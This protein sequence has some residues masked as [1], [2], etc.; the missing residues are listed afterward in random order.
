MS[1]DALYFR[2]SSDRQTAEN[3]FDDLIKI[4]ERDSSG[5]DW[6]KIRRL[7]TLSI[8]E[9]HINSPSGPRVRYRINPQ[10]ADQLASLAVYVE[11]GRSGKRGKLRVLFQRMKHD[12]AAR[13]F[14]R[15]LVWK[16]SR[17]SRD[18]REVI[19]TVYQLND[20]G[21]TVVPALRLP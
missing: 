4:A 1:I 7:L 17:L 12:A 9:D 21:V 8:I 6:T 16:V 14:S 20:L 18:M 15:L 10:F 13:K 3:Q 11:Q 19:D 2:V 5:R